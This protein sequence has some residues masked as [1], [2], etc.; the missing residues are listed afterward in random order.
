MPGKPF[1][2]AAVLALAGCAPL[3]ELCR[4]GEQPAAVE[5]LYLG[6]AKGESIA[7]RPEDWKAFLDQAVTPRFPQGFTWWEAR[8]QWRNGA[9]GIERE[10][11]YI[12]QVVQPEADGQS[13]AALV[14]IAAR[15]RERF[16]QEAVLRIAGRACMALLQPP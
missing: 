12:L 10:R 13:D 16:G 8:G 4:P 9:G 2:I 11:S 15:Y 14:E 3:P 5:T 7:V 6:T 1:A